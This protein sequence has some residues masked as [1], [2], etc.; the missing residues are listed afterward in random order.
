[1]LS[2]RQ[3]SITPTSSREAIALRQAYTP[4]ALTSQYPTTLQ[5][6]ITGAC[7]TI[8]LCREIKSPTIH[9]LAE[10]YP[11]IQKDGV[12]TD[13][14][15]V[16]WMQAQL[17]AVC[18]FANVRAKLNDWQ[19]HSIAQQILSE[20]PATTMIEFIL[21]CARLRSGAYEGFYGAVDPTKVL[22]SFT[23]FEQD[24]R[25]DYGL[26]YERQEK[27]RQ[28]REE[29]EARQAAVGLDWLQ[30]QVEKGE[31]QNVGKLLGL[32]KEK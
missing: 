24:K 8:D 21:F 17:I 31:L 7:P 10:A 27:Q 25:R 11:P 6:T 5:E 32:V 12:E 3:T 18:A 15:A 22:R 19:L 9:T 13:S 28:E 1:M 20:Y 4:A 14:V 2:A 16:L 26:L 29:Q 30:Q 23:S